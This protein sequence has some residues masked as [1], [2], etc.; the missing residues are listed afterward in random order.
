LHSFRAGNSIGVVVYRNEDFPVQVK[1]V[2]GM[3]CHPETRPITSH[4]QFHVFRTYPVING[5]IDLTWDEN[6]EER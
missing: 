4:D 5:K 1:K 6:G 3:K 2:V